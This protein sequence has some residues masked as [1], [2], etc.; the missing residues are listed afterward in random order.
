MDTDEVSTHPTMPIRKSAMW[1]LPA[2]Q[3]SELFSSKKRQMSSEMQVLLY[4]SVKF[5]HEPMASYTRSSCLLKYRRNRYARVGGEP[6]LASV[7]GFDLNLQEVF[8]YNA[9]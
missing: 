4:T 3:K 1:M 9:N 8:V 2:S 5:T 6:G 7:P